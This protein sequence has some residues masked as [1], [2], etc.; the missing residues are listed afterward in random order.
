MGWNPPKNPDE[1][2]KGNL[3][4][5][6]EMCYFL[7]GKDPTQPWQR[8]SISGPSV[9]GKTVVGTNPFS[10]GLGAGDVNGDGRLD[11]ICADGWWEQPEKPDG[12]PWKFHGAKIT[13]PC[14]DM[15]VL[16]IDGDGKGDIISASAHYWGF[17]WS[18][19]KDANS[20]VQRTLFRARSTSRNCRRAC[21]WRRKNAACLKRSMM[22]QGAFSRSPFAAHPSCAMAAISQERIAKSNAKEENINGK[23]PG[24]VLAVHTTRVMPPAT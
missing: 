8:I 13:N 23:Y 2:T 21:N 19:Q 22:S 9:K 20:F 10:H 18:Q 6:G 1:P 11:V 5:M 14:S 12:K 3:D 24:K 16:D 15:Y 4:G 7:P 17:W